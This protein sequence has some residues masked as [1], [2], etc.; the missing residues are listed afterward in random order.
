M[1]KRL[2]TRFSSIF[3][4]KKDFRLAGFNLDYQLYQALDKAGRFATDP[5]DFFP[6]LDDNTTHS[7]FDGHYVYHPA[8]AARVV[9]TI[10]PKEHVDISSTLHFC[11]IL[12]AFTKTT[13]YD[14][15]PAEIHLDNL[16]S[17]KADLTNLHFDSGSIA[18][19]SC[20]HTIEHVGLG[21]Y[22]DPIDP[23]G[24]LKAI[25]QLMRV[26]AP[27]G[28]LLVVVPV[29]KKRIMFNAHR[30][31][32]PEEFM[33][34][35]E[36]FTLE[37]FSLVTDDNNFIYNASFTTAAAQRYGCGCYWLKKQ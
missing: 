16:T 15:R 25:Q 18:C 8:W 2:L 14:F 20:M 12:S 24:D 30:I 11:A 13:F 9:K 35:F 19:L 27:H 3:S 22:G 33:S 21:R 1:L 34:Y 5:S 7:N 36:G 17:L 4:R 32:D 26:C 31:Y 6:C 29:G 37:N 10:S 28:D 23:D